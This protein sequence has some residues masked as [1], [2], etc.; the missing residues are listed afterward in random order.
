MSASL[1]PFLPAAVLAAAIV[2]LAPFIGEVRDL[3]FALLPGR[4]PSV[5]AAAFAVVGAVAVALA[6][7]RIHER[8]LLRVGLLSLAVGVAVLQGRVFDTGLA[9]ANVVE[10]LH[11]LEYGLLALL[12]YRPLRRSGDLSA[13]V[14][15]LL[16]VVAVG[17]VDEY[18]QWL[19][20]RR[21]GEIRDVGLNLWS[22][23]VGLL[24]ALAV[25][26]PEGMRPGLSPRRACLVARAA[27]LTL[28]LA[29]LF[30][31]TAHVGHWIEDPEIGRFRSWHTR[32]ELRAA[33]VDRGVRWAADP[34]REVPLLG[35]EDRFLT[36]AAEHA[37]HFHASWRAGDYDSAWH[38]YRVLERFYAPFLE[39]RSFQSGAP[40]RIVDA[41]REA[42]ER[43]SRRR[44]PS[45]RTSPVLAPRIYPRP[46]RAVLLA[47]LFPTV[48]GV[49]LL[50]DLVGAARPR[51]R[52]QRVVEPKGIEPST[53]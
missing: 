18:A 21:V 47:L 8:R 37:M 33:A 36:E 35:I 41:S 46:T 10:K 38:A 53:S 51:T 31:S 16:G 23:V 12:L 49:A 39:V 20:P 42:L 22:G 17:T 7:R 3:V 9:Q 32:E 34:P 52:G 6:A 11:L 5:L 1:R 26:P 29:G 24:F 28:L 40:H 15:P 48:A 14:L 43:R 27:G 4:A 25:A 19:A 2:A 13:V 44:Y 50:P 45:G 30:W